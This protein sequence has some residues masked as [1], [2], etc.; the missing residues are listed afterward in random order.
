MRTPTSSQPSTPTL[1]EDALGLLQRRVAT[2]TGVFGAINLAGVVVRAL[3]LLT[4][5]G[6]VASVLKSTLLFQAG[7]TAA[8]LSVWLI[9]RRERRSA[10]VVR[11]AEALGLLV[12]GLCYHAVA[13]VL[14]LEVIG[15]T[16]LR[17]LAAD[18]ET[19]LSAWFVMILPLA[20]VSYLL[21]Y[22]MILRAAF[23]PS[24]AKRTALLTA[25]VGAPLIVIFW[26]TGS[27]TA[28]MNLFVLSPPM[29]ALGGVVQWGFTVIV[30]AS[31]SRVIY[32]LRQEVREAKRLG[33]YTLEELIGE[34][35]M[36]RV[37]KA[38]HAMLRRPTAI[39]LLPPDRA[40]HEAL[41]RF[42]A[43]VQLTACLTHP[44]TVTIY[45]YGRTADGVLY[46]AMELLDGATLEEVV[47]V[48][49]PQRPSRVVRILEQVAG[50]LGEAHGIGLIHRDIKPANIVLCRQGGELDVAKVVDFG[51]VKQL[52]QG[53]GATVSQD[54]TISGTPLYMA[55]EVLTERGTASERSD[56]YALG[57]VGYY[58]LT[59]QPLFDGGSVIEILGHHLH[60]PPVPPSERLGEPLPEDL[61]RVILDCLAKDPDARPQNAAELRR[62]LEA[63]DIPPFKQRSAQLW[64]EAHGV[65]LGQRRRP[66]IR[67]V[68]GENASTIAIDLLRRR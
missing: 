66:R 51:L 11:T 56:I 7:A 19:L 47:D 63:C 17:E 14:T 20:A 64:W 39:K 67:A 61:S 16:A 5:E 48:D 35:G 2:F 18:R 32:G 45:D 29:L 9:T 43:E 68:A 58:L 21:T 42:E 23:V 49:G 12:T 52:D 50:A 60:T 46:Y 41:V 62:R 65:N 1:T 28:P 22:A 3:L 59:G 36:G 34:G 33:Q 25:M 38:S 40:G 57:A 8:L 55:P 6:E 24:T 26:V 10:R 31:I 27:S 15:T 30:C 4:L 53:P 37:Y 54:G 13:L 44:N